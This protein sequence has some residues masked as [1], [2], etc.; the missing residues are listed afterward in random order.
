VND[1]G[2]PQGAPFA[3]MRSIQSYRVHDDVSFCRVEGH[4][5]FLDIKNDRYFRLPEARERAFLAYVENGKCPDASLDELAELNILTAESSIPSCTSSKE[6]QCPIRSAVEEA[7]PRKR[8][9]IGALLGVFAAICSTN[10]Q[11]KRRPLKSILASLVAYRSIRTSQSLASFVQPA[12]EQLTEAVAVFRRLRLWIPIN[13]CCLLD[14]IALVRFLAKR[15]MHA[16]IVFG[17]TGDPFSAHCWVQVGEL[18][19]NDT[20]GN[21]NAYTPIRTV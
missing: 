4:L 19:L 1:L 9:R 10:L 11:L 13:T 5:I 20:L 7:S 17:V 16:N 12:S 18:V 3:P 8:V 14:S 15:R 21:V 6:M 2:A